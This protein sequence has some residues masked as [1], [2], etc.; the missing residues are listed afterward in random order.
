MTVPEPEAVT[1]SRDT[2][3]TLP[4]QKTDMEDRI[5]DVTILLRR[6]GEGNAAVENELY[7]LVYP[8]LKRCARIIRRRFHRVH[9]IETTEL[10]G[11]VYIRLAGVV[12]NQDWRNR[13]HFYAFFARSM[14]RYLLDYLRKWYKAELVSFDGQNGMAAPTLPIHDAIALDQ[15]LDK[16]A[17]VDSN[18]ATVVRMKCFL[19]FTDREVADALQIPLRTIQKMWLEARQW[20]FVHMRGRDASKGPRR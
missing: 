6:L 19:G 1:N 2:C 8:D 13:Q 20:L 3:D 18:W 5:G 17:T 9:D 4:D 10:I 12:E 14:Q 7:D 11:N 15:L 16:L